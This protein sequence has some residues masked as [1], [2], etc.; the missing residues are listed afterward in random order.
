MQ[1]AL[2]NSCGL[3]LPSSF[4]LLRAVSKSPI[5]RVAR[6]APSSGFGSRSGNCALSG[7]NLIQAAT[8][9]LVQRIVVLA[10]ATGWPFLSF[11]YNLNFRAEYLA[12]RLKNINFERDFLFVLLMAISVFSHDLHF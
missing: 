10:L 11:G 9:I 2:C 3:P 8:Y 4:T 6:S 1:C 12:M 5:G 7:G